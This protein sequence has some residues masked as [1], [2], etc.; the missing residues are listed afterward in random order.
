MP[1][2]IFQST[3]AFAVAGFCA[4]MTYWSPTTDKPGTSTML[5]FYWGFMVVVAL[6]CGVGLL[7]A[8]VIK[9]YGDEND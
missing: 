5:E 6:A 9:E 1:T 3:L 7:I 8:W 2:E 4:L